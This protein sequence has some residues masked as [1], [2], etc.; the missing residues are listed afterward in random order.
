MGIL[1]GIILSYTYLM[2]YDD[3]IKQYYCPR[4]ADDTICVWFEPE[5]PCTVKMIYFYFTPNGVGGTAYYPFIA[6][7]R[8]SVTLDSFNYYVS[9]G[10]SPIDSIVWQDTSYIPAVEGWDSIAVS[11]YHSDTAPFIVGYVLGT[12]NQAILS[13]YGALFPAHSLQYRQSPPSGGPG[14]Y[15]HELTDF[16]IRAKVATPYEWRNVKYVQGRVYGVWDYDTVYVC[17]DIMVDTVPGESLKIMPGVVVCFRDTWKFTVREKLIA[18]GTPAES[19]KFIPEDTVKGWKG[20]YGEL[21][22]KTGW[23]KLCYAYIAYVKGRSAVEIAPIDYDYC[24]QETLRDNRIERCETKYGAITVRGM[25]QNGCSGKVWII[26][27]EISK[28][29]SEK[30]AI[31]VDSLDW[32]E[33]SGSAVYIDSN[34]IY[35]CDSNAIYLFLCCAIYIRENEIRDN[36]GY[37]I[38]FDPYIETSAISGGMTKELDGNT[39]ENNGG[40]LWGRWSNSPN[41]YI[42]CIENNII[43]NNNRLKSS[44]E[45]LEQGI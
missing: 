12:N 22:D 40:V 5:T 11:Y 33:P 34:K 17:G 20:I 14:W 19:I 39:I 26:N 38:S 24:G 7:V 43:R 18:E 32:G 8:E 13:D 6:T 10:P 44:V 30:G 37:A 31:V 9:P 21:P 1:L 16:M 15:N 2:H 25:V 27:N 29:T 41:A 35:E 45:L 42:A 28:I 3:G 23:L 36:T 4:D